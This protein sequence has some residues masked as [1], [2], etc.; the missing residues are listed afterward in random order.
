MTQAG[1]EENDQKGLNVAGT[2]R[3]QGPLNCAD[4]QQ[5]PAAQGGSFL[6]EVIGRREQGQRQSQKQKVSRAG[7]QGAPERRGDT[8]RP[9]VR[10]P[11]GRTVTN[12]SM[13]NT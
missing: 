2:A 1:G 7:A 11:F 3:E 10:E 5:E 13:I 8:R 9:G 6:V 4:D 12:E